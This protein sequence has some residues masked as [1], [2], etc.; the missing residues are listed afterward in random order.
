MSSSL[1]MQMNHQGIRYINRKT[2]FM[3]QRGYGLR[4]IAY[5]LLSE[6]SQGESCT[7]PR[8]CTPLPRSIQKGSQC[9]RNSLKCRT[10]SLKHYERFVIQTLFEDLAIAKM[11]VYSLETVLLIPSQLYFT[12]Q[13][14]KNRKNTDLFFLRSYADFVQTVLSHTDIE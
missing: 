6:T 11:E 9:L 12:F 7:L 10:F 2:F 1:P 13:S 4:W 14:L 5:D 3:F 8:G